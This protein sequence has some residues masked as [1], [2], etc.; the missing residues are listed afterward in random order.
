MLAMMAVSI[1]EIDCVS[2]EG[3]IPAVD[4]GKPTW[5]V[6]GVVHL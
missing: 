2:P 4:V 6:G 5:A 3:W 1:A